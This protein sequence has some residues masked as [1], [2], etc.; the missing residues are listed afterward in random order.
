M[1]IIAL[2]VDSTSTFT[3]CVERRLMAAEQITKSCHCPH[4]Q[5]RHHHRHL[6]SN[7]NFVAGQHKDSVSVLSELGT[8][9]HLRTHRNV[10]YSENFDSLSLLL[11]QNQT[12]D[13][14]K[15]FL[16]FQCFQKSNLKKVNF[17]VFFPGLPWENVSGVGRLC[18][19]KGC[20]GIFQKYKS[21]G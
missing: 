2:P 18:P 6:S 8:I 19:R 13:G 17:C 10:S 16:L 4:H 14:M 9:N 3:A 21:I 5:H 20:R 15:V 12:Y 7:Q 1:L 11:T